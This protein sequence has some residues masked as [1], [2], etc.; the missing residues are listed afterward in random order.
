MTSITGAAFILLTA[1]FSSAEI[2]QGAYTEGTSK[3]FE[4][5]F[6]FSLIFTIYLSALC[7]TVY[8]G[9]SGL[10]AVASYSLGTAH[11]PGYPLF[12]LMGKMLSFLPFGSIAYKVNLASALFGALETPDDHQARPVA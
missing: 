2:Y 1:L 10:F 5:I 7:P 9:D 8:M 6:L 11:P 3:Q 4:E 12:I